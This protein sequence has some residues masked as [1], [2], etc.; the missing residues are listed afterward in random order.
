ML[1]F[2]ECKYEASTMLIAKRIATS[3]KNVHDPAHHLAHFHPYII[4]EKGTTLAT[5]KAPH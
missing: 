4:R 3:E 1:K 2:C 5:E